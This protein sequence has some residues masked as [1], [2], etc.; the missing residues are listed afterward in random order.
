MTTEERAE[1]ANMIAMAIETKV[2]E[3]DT[4]LGILHAWGPSI[5]VPVICLGGIAFGVWKGTPRFIAWMTERE[6][7]REDREDKIRE[8]FLE[9]LRET[10]GQT[11]D[12]LHELADAV[13]TSCPMRSGDVQ[14][15][16]FTQDH[17]PT[18]RMR[19]R[20]VHGD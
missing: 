5:A 6:K 10:S 8:A 15:Q 20:A 12:A 16:Q 2:H 11:E 3:P 7:A 9:T 17:T 18:T 1:I 13:R 19:R 14:I 4:W